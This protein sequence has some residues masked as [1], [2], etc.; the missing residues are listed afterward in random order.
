MSKVIQVGARSCKNISNFTMT[1]VG[2]LN[3]LTPFLGPFIHRVDAVI[4]LAISL[5]KNNGNK[6]SHSSIEIQSILEWSNSMDLN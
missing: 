2:K 1:M 4:M 3:I 6:L 5:I